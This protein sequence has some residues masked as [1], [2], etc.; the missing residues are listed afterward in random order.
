MTDIR[1]VYKLDILDEDAR[2]AFKSQLSEASKI[3]FLLLEKSAEYKDQLNDLCLEIIRRDEGLNQGY[4][5]LVS[6]NN[7]NMDKLRHNGCF[8]CGKPGQMARDCWT[9]LIERDDSNDWW[10][11]KEK[12]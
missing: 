10:A 11:S 6:A 1:T 4:E 12:Y 8:N 9:R 2:K 3:S 5:P 7:I